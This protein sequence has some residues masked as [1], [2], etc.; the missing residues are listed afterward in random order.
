MN[1]TA[2]R[3]TNQRRTL[4]AFGVLAACLL[5]ASGSAL[6]ATSADAAPS[7]KV[8]YGDLNLTSD[9]GNSALY[10]R[11][12]AAARQVCF[13]GG[14]DI[15]DLARYSQARSCEAQAIAQAV[16]A[17]HSPRLAAIYEARQPRG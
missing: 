7:I 2:T 16:H 6:A 4:A 11:I 5:G 8:A 10:A 3:F 1:P 12:A 9:E 17:V 14:A 13:A 15:R